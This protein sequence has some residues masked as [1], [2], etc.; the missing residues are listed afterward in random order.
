MGAALAL[1]QVAQW[2]MLEIEGS[3]DIRKRMAEQRHPPSVI[4]M[5]VPA[6]LF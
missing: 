6:L 2:Q 5:V 3:P 1:R 4:C